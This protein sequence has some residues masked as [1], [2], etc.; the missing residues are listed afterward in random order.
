[1]LAVT[2]YRTF[3]TSSAICYIPNAL[4]T[5]RHVFLFASRSPVWLTK[6]TLMTTTY[7]PSSQVDLYRKIN[8][9]LPATR[10]LPLSPS[11]AHHGVDPLE[12]CSLEHVLPA[13]LQASY[14]CGIKDDCVLCDHRW[15]CDGR[16]GGRGKRRPSLCWGAR[17]GPLP[18]LAFTAGQD[19][20]QGVSEL[21]RAA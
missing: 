3:Y 2:P 5:F 12:D 7:E 9:T 16:G 19:D 13:V 8:W 6:F 14:H 11:F 18:F 1:M 10:G 20:G 15:K 21:Q 4:C 17:T